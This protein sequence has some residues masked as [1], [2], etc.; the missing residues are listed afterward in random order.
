MVGVAVAKYALL[1]IGGYGESGRHMACLRPQISHAGWKSRP[2]SRRNDQFFC[3][4]LSAR[5]SA[6]AFSVK[7]YAVQRQE[8]VNESRDLK[9]SVLG[10]GQVT[11]AREV[12]K[13][14]A[15]HVDMEFVNQALLR[16]S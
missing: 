14:K 8:R 11:R 6:K 3:A 15:E 4:T 2:L 10:Q 5:E 9:S 16:K 1:T 13:A 12:A 7:A